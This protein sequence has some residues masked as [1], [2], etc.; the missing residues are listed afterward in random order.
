MNRELLEEVAQ[1]LTDARFNAMQ[2][3]LSAGQQAMIDGWADLRSRI[4]AALSAPQ[5]DAMEVVGLIVDIYRKADDDAAAREI[6]VG[7]EDVIYD[8]AKTEAASLIEDF[9]KRVPKAFV[10]DLY[11]IA[12]GT[13]QGSN[14]MLPEEAKSRIADKFGVK[15]EDAG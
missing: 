8:K 14:L 2:G 7:A 1:A 15:V 5:P 13:G 3:P 9:G 6:G 4:T 10:D 11:S 12:F